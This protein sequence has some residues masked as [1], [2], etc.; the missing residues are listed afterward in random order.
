MGLVIDSVLDQTV[1]S[2]ET[3]LKMKKIKCHVS[4]N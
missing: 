1:K 4:K 3:T 2:G